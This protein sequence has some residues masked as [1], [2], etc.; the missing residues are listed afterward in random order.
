MIRYIIFIRLKKF[1]GNEN[2]F[3]FLA[4][5]LTYIKNIVSI[6]KYDEKEQGTSFNYVNYHK[7]KI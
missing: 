1:I 3:N 7:K 4:D 6:N 2:Y 5:H